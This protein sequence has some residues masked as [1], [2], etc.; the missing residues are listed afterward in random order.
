MSELSER[1]KF[2]NQRI[3]TKSKDDK[4]DGKTE[5]FWEKEEG[6][7]CLRWP[8]RENSFQTEESEPDWL[9]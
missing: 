7:S 4:N 5:K 1:N 6:E 3:E 8:R 2:Q 9:P